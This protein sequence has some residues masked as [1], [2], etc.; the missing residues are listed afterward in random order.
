MKKTILA[1]TLA[2]GVFTAG[3][4][5]AQA[6]I[7]QLMPIAANFCPVGW[8]KADGSMLPIAQNAALFSVIGTTYGGNGTTT[9]ALP[10]M[11]GSGTIG[12]AGQPMTWCIANTG[13]QMPPKG[14]AKP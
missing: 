9:F 5:G 2:L 6:Y 10:K 8:L 12:P 13:A 4:A 14:K 3:A 1:A 7:S 11:S